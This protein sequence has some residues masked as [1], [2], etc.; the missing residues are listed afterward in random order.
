MISIPM[1]TFFTESPSL[2]NDKDTGIHMISLPM[3]K[4]QHDFS[5]VLSSRFCIL[6][7]FAFQLIIYYRLVAYLND[8]LTT[9]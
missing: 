5:L 1:V 9:D 4:V 2:S 8:S 7:D 3:V 6:P